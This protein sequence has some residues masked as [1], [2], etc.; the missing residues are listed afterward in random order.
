MGKVVKLEKGA[1]KGRRSRRARAVADRA[2][3]RRRRLHRRRL[4]DRRPACAR[5]AV[6]QPQ[7]QPVRH[8]RRHERRLADRRAGGERDHARAD[9]ADRQQPGPDAVPRHQPRHAAAAEL[10]RVRGQGGPAAAAPDGR[11]ALARPQPRLVLARRHRDRARRRPAV[12]PLHRHR[13]SRSTSAPC[14]PTPTAPTTSACCRTSSTSPPR[15]S[16]RAS[17]SCSAPRAGTTCRSRPPCAPRPRCRWSTSPPGS[18][19]AS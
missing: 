19:T 11:R 17:G 12:R 3:A 18:R 16:T 10:P 8:L 13:G 14:S 7:R 6:G 9:D 5:P 15:T 4:R 1:S 2:R